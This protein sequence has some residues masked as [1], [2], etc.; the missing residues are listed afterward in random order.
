MEKYQP[1]KDIQAIVMDMDG[2]LL[3]S[4]NKIT[5]LTKEVLMDLEKKGVELI[6]AS[7]RSYTRLMSYAKDLEMDKYNGQLLEVDGIAVYDL[8]PMKRNVLHRMDAK[9]IHQVFDYLIGKP[10][11]AMACFDDGLYDHI[12]EF[13]IPIKK[14]LREE[15]NVDEDFPWT[16]GPWG[17]LQDLRKG[18]PKITYVKSADEIKGKINKIQIMVDEDQIQPLFEDLTA[19]FGD[20]FEIFRTTPRQLEILPKGFSK[21]QTLKKIIAEKGW[22]PNKV[23]VFGD[24]ENDVSL[25]EAVPN[26]FAMEN[27]MDYVK[28]KSRYIAG[29]HDEDGIVSGLIREGFIE[30]K[31]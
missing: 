15:M 8:K 4:E 14:K 6:L 7:G 1:K 22:D 3:N 17:W 21:G 20:E 23:I 19:K 18:Y 28:E 24:G 25:F 12:P 5:P 11:E 16:A 9:D 26:S 10:C 31:E 13:L 2:T 27:A 30:V 29:N